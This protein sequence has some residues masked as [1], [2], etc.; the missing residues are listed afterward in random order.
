VTASAI[1]KA[2]GALTIITHTP[3]RNLSKITLH[4]D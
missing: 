2:E 1:S 4:V 3:L